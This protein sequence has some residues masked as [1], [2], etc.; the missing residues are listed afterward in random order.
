MIKA[1]IFGIDGVLID[2]EKWHYQYWREAAQEAGFEIHHAQISALCS[3]DDAQALHY[4]SGVLGREF[5][6]EMVGR[7][8]RELME[9]HVSGNGVKRK[10]G[11]R[12]VLDYLKANQIRTVV[13]VSGEPSRAEDYL[14]RAGLLEKIDDVICEVTEECGRQEADLYRYVCGRIGLK[15]EECAAVEA[16]PGCVRAAAAAGLYTIMVP[17]LVKPEKEEEDL[18]RMQID[19]L[20]DIILMLEDGII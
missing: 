6:C 1:V 11:A 15:T 2:T 14:V 8:K 9:M 10:T 19:T 12:D 13:A 4:L 18:I 20:Y 7:R 17:D 5:P 3:G 16:F